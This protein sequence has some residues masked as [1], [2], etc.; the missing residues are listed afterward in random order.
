MGG[1]Q[2]VFSMFIYKVYLTYNLT[3]LQVLRLSEMGLFLNMLGGRQVILTKYALTS[4]YKQCCL[5]IT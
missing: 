2:K 1:G 4:R 3:Y 5:F